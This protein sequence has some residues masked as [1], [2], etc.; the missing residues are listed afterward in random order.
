MNS[1]AME[2]AASF[3]LSN[4][5]PGFPYGRA[6]IGA[7]AGAYRTGGSTPTGPN[8]PSIFNIRGPNAQYFAEILMH[9]RVEISA[10][11]QATG[12]SDE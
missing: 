12:V 8:S 2:P 9:D 4:C 5:A 7:I 3:G 11:P 10:P 6:A 1:A